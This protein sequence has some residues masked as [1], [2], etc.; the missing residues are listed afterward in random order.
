MFYEKKIL[1][2][3]TVKTLFTGLS[4]FTV[5]KKNSLTTAL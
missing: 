1:K 4:I 2:T 3:I 5:E